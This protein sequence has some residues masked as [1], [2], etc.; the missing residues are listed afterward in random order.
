MQTVLYLLQDRDMYFID[1]YTSQNTVGW[2]MAEKLGIPTG[3]RTVFLDN[4]ENTEYIRGQL[5][6]LV[7]RAGALGSAIGIGHYRRVTYQVL[8][9]YIPYYES[10]GVRFVRISEIV[11][12]SELEETAGNSRQA[13]TM[14]GD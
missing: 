1:S 6:E 10:Q 12:P 14:S 4:E 3:K 8:R 7:T 13:L 5:E 9:K 2:E 11:Q